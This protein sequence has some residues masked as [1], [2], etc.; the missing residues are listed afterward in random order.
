M[1]EIIKTKKASLNIYFDLKIEKTSN[2][3]FIC[4]CLFFCASP[5]A[6]Y[7]KQIGMF[8]Q[9]IPEKERYLGNFVNVIKFQPL[10]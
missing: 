6:V 10:H 4:E 7:I 8:A 3:C 2:P 5:D 9:N 1:I